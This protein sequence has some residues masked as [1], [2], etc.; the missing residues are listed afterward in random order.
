MSNAGGGERGW[1]R[2]PC[3]LL[4]GRGRRG[5]DWGRGG[6]GRWAGGSDEGDFGSTEGRSSAVAVLDGGSDLGL[7]LAKNQLQRSSGVF[8]AVVAGSEKGN[9]ELHKSKLFPYV[10]PKKNYTLPLFKGRCRSG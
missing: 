6:G 2:L 10:S 4:G 5:G 7:D 9:I 8:E 1:G 3:A